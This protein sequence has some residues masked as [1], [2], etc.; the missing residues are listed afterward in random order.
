M[1]RSG[2]RLSTL[3]SSWPRGMCSA[4]G[5]APCSYSSGSRTSRTTAP[6]RARAS[7]RPWPCRPRGFPAW[8]AGAALGS[9]PWRYLSSLE[10]LENPT[11]SVD[12]PTSTGSSSLIESRSTTSAKSSI[13][14]GSALRITMRA[15]CCLAERD[16][17][18]HG[19]DAERGAHG[20]Q[21]IA[22]PGGH[23]GADQVIL[24][25][26]LPERDGG[27]LQDAAAGAARRIL[28]ARLHPSER[29][30]HRR[31]LAARQA[32]HFAGVS[33][34]LDQA[35]GIG[36]RLVM[37]PVDVLRDERD[38]LAATLE[39]DQRTVARVRLDDLVDVVDPRAPRRAP[40]VGLVDVVLQVRRL[41]G[42][43]ILRPE[44]VRTT[45][46]GDPTVGRDARAREHDDA[47]GVVD[48]RLDGVD[49]LDHRG[50]V[51]PS[52]RN[53]R[54]PPPSTRSSTSSGLNE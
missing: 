18:G 19:I 38:Q 3:D 47:I 11:Q 28:L 42:G 31:P 53:T 45:E 1:V 7:R 5:M 26:R 37:Q 50:H 16:H 30:F 46:I 43:R 14:V 10:P 54:N 33:V 34:D 6:A 17:V 24:D 23:V 25:Q 36:P 39:L 4:P 35:A 15:P 21:Q 8:P 41:L 51:K 48:P 12:I 52:G 2:I 13:S 49:I 44:P 20:Q 40:N 9:S 27:C 32:H 29:P 22:G